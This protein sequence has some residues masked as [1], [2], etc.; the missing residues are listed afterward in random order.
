MQVV[1]IN[2]NKIVKVNPV[3]TNDHYTAVA[4]LDIQLPTTVSLQFYGKNQNTDTKVDQ[5]GNVIQDICVIIKSMKLDGMMVDQNFLHNRVLLTTE[6]QQECLGSYIG[7]NGT[8]TIDL[9]TNNVFS[10]MIEFARK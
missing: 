8:M 6:D 10:Q 1:V 5:N 7:F 9:V 4:Q 2:K 3:L